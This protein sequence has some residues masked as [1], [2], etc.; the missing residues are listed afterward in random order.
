MLLLSSPDRKT[1]F[2]FACL[3]LV[4]SL[5]YVSCPGKYSTALA[6]ENSRLP[7]NSSLETFQVQTREITNYYQAVGSI[8][9]WHEPSI[10]ALVQARIQEVLVQPGDRAQPGELLIRLDDREFK[11]RLNQ[12]R[13]D[14]E[15]NQAALS[16]IREEISE[17]RAALEEAEPEFQR[18]KKLYEQDVATQQELDRAKSAYFQA[19]ARH[20]QALIS[21]QEARATQESLREKIRE[22]EIKLEYTEI[23][24]PGKAEV[25][26][27]KVEPG[28]TAAPGKT[29]LRVQTRHLLRME[30][31]VPERVITHINMDQQIRLRVDALDKSLE[32]KVREIEPAADPAGRNFLVK[33]AI[34]HQNPDLYPG[35]FARMH[36]PVEK[37]KM[38]LVPEDAIRR[39]GQLPTVHVIRDQ[40][41]R[42]R[43]VRLGREIDG[44]LEVLSGL[45]PGEEIKVWPTRD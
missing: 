41:T 21:L 23:R 9:P 35:M 31:L 28:D 1:C 13:H 44:Y 15:A 10:E 24:A 12:A 32:G 33:V 8:R 39:I 11:S 38:I 36:V 29:L 26:K 34:D 37:E 25:V 27:T 14:L 2:V 30:A 5:V 40:E 18:L 19:R 4:L 7:K 16:R 20:E 42:T 3:F 45:E 43:H 22:L 17:A 6:D